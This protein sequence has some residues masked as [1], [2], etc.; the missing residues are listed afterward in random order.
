MGQRAP[1]FDVVDIYGRHVSLIE[2]VGKRVLLSFY[3]AAVCPL[4]N[5]RTWHIMNRYHEWQRQGLEVVAF[6]ESSPERSHEYLDR[7]HAPFPVVADLQRAV[8]AQYGME[9]S[10]FGAG[11]ARLTRWGMYREAAQRGIGGNLI[12]N[13]TR[14]DGKFGRLPADFILG[15]DLR[16][17]HAYYGRDAGDFMLLSE[18]EH[19]AGLR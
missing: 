18:I 11:W 4:C 9:S 7:L 16:I 12:A 1:N 3:R 15:P 14:M 19:Y 13:V 17:L 10:V 2:Y 6:Y 5:V 8:Y